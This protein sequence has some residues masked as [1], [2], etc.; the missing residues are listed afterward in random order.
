MKFFWDGVWNN[1]KKAKTPS[2]EQNVLMYNVQNWPFIF[3]YLLERMII[4]LLSGKCYIFPNYHNN[5]KCC[6]MK[7][8][9]SLLRTK[10]KRFPYSK[11]ISLNS[12]RYTHT[13]L[14]YSCLRRQHFKGGR[15]QGT[16]QSNVCFISCLMTHLHLIDFWICPKI[17]CMCARDKVDWSS[18]IEIE[19][20]KMAA[21]KSIGAQ[22]C[23]NLSL[24]FNF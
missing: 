4:D 16:S 22:F 13:C 3:F 10:Y 18:R 19:K 20:I 14:H 2:C 8:G 12:V 23:V 7:C 5:H 9:R 6:R 11:L 15:H 1:T 17:R 21:K 24:I